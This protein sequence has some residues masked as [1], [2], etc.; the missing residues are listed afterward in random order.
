MHTLDTLILHLSLI[1]GIGPVTV[2]QIIEVLEKHQLISLAYVLKSSDIQALGVSLK[3]AQTVVEGLS[4]K[5]LLFQE[6][7]YYEKYSIS[8]ATYKDERYPEFL[9]NI[10]AP[11]AVITWQGSLSY[12]K[13]LAVVGSRDANE[14]GKRV[15]NHFVPEL[16]AHGFTIVSGGAYGIDAWAHQAALECQGKTIVVLGSGLLKPYPYEHKKLFEKVIENGGAVLS[17]F[18]CTASAAPGNFP[19]RNRVIAGLSHGCVVVQAALKSGAKITADY[20]LQQGRSVFAV[21]GP[22]DHHL[23]QGCNELIK[24]GATMLTTFDDIAQEFGI[25]QYRKTT[26]VQQ[27]EFETEVIVK[28]A[29]SLQEKKV[30]LPTKDVHPVVK[31]CQVPQSFDELLQKFP[32]KNPAQLQ[33]LLFD[34]S[35]EGLIEQDFSGCWRSLF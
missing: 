29:R 15:V 17:I 9:K 35:L 26:V 22:F 6:L 16:V 23:S 27:S 20:A 4:N 25:T 3:T 19:A 33:D 1:K 5:E 24:Q 28:P 30:S 32:E 14:Y 18:P 31:V 34:L 2:T 12:D 8:W 13:A 10:Y 21:P 11:P 7:S